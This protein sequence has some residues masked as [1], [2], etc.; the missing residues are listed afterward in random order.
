MTQ[1]KQNTGYL[2]IHN[3]KYIMNIKQEFIHMIKLLKKKTHSIY[4]SRL[5]MLVVL[6]ECTVFDSPICLLDILI[7]VSHLKYFPL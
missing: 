4:C 3:V 6:K 5:T 7:K 1:N 2:I